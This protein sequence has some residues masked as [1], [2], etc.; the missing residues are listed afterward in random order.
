MAGVEKILPYGGSGAKGEEVES[1]FDSIA[2]AYDLMN[3]LMSL[4]MHKRWRDKALDK[5]L[6]RCGSSVSE[7]LDVATGTGDL[8]FELGRRLP[9]S[10]LH[11]IDLSRG[12]LCKA[13]KR[14]SALPESIRGRIE[15][16]QGDC[17]CLPYKDSAFDLVS[18]AY[19]V[20]NFAD[21]G[22]G[23]REMLRVLK[24]G[25]VLCVVELACPVSPL[26]L[27]A[28]KLYTRGLIPAAGKLISGDRRAYSYLH[29]SIE[30][31][32]QRG[33]MVSIMEEAGFVKAEWLGLF[34]GVVCI[35]LA[36]KRR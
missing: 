22:R 21:L 18:V 13:E 4:G 30:A 11:G 10:R 32:P 7:I 34:P 1:M 9:E 35:Y 23:Y 33:K 16:R 27:A 26:P 31:A 20:R 6:A 24:P 14:V 5:A 2:P 3:S 28:Y 36:E 29:E 17:L 25:G 8:L 15:F 19:G 12:M